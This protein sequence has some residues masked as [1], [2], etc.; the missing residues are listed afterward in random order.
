MKV[1]A[2]FIFSCIASVAGNNSFGGFPNIFVIKYLR[3]GF[4]NLLCH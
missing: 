1:R 4:E 3:E 2:H